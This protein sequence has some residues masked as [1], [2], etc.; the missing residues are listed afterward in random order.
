MGC[1]TCGKKHKLLQQAYD[2]LIPPTV[3][4]PVGSS[5]KR[6]PVRGVIKSTPVV[7]PVPEKPKE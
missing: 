2:P 5:F 6:M 7:P 3:T 1:S 4:R